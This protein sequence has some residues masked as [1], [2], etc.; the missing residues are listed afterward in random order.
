MKTNLKQIT[1]VELNFTFFFK[2][3]LGRLYFVHGV[4]L[5][6]AVL[7]PMSNYCSITTSVTVHNDNAFKKEMWTLQLSEILKLC[8]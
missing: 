1:R 5:Y 4:K 3:L 6:V 2:I 7:S 8:L